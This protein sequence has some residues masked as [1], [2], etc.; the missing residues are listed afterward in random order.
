MT[1]LDKSEL[2]KKGRR[3]RPQPAQNTREL[4]SPNTNYYLLIV[5]P[6][7]GE[8]AETLKND[9]NTGK[10]MKISETRILGFPDGRGGQIIRPVTKEFNPLPA[11]FYVNWAEVKVSSQ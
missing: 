3:D 8:E 9:E 5:T 10:V 4:A 6:A 2:R 1:S 11:D 7:P